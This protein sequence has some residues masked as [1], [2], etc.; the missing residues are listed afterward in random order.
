MKLYPV[1]KGTYK[2]HIYRW[3]IY[4][5]MTD[6]LWVDLFIN[7]IDKQTDFREKMTN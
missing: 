3:I 7:S 4:S 1:S 5:N 2:V 6:I